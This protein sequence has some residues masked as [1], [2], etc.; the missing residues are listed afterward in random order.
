MF[1]GSSFNQDI[2]S[3]DVSNVTDMSYMFSG[4]SFNQDISSWDVSNVTDM[5]S[6]FFGSSFNQDI[7]SWVVPNGDKKAL[8]TYKYEDDD[9]PF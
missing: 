7:S 1:S 8:F 3:W 4:S 6:M 2:S 9:L 5:R